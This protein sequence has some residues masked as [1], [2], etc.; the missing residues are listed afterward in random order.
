MNATSKEIAKYLSNILQECP[1]DRS[2]NGLQVD[3][4]KP[5]KHVYGAVDA[6]EK[7]FFST[8]HED[9][10]LF[11]VHHGLFWKGVQPNI[12][13][14]NFTKIKHLIETNSSL[15]ASH[16]P[17]DIHPSL[18]NNASLLS[19]LSPIEETIKRFCQYKGYDIGLSATLN[20]SVNRK[21]IQALYSEALVEKTTLLAFGNEEVKRIAVCSGDGADFIS[22][23]YEAGVDLFITGEFSHTMYV[24]AQD[25]NMNVLCLTHYGSEKNGVLNLC[26]K[27]RDAFNIE[28]TFVDFSPMF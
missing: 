19:F 25:H 4:S 10:S 2:W 13:G 24:Y 16:L 3:S 18:G 21:S 20:N 22:D 1:L 12:E 14:S 11:I 7:L 6:S 9:S 15:Y 17:L 27:V 8:N 26:E 5:I 28:F 23:A